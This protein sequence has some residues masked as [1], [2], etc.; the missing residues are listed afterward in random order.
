[1]RYLC[2]APKRRTWFQIETQTEADAESA[3]MRHSVEKYFERAIA[4]ARQ[5]YEPRPGLAFFE[6]D[7]GMKDHV[8]RT[9]PVFATL[10]DEEGTGLATAM[11]PPKGES[12]VNHRIIIVGADNADP[13]RDHAEAIEALGRYLGYRLD[14]AS[15]FPYA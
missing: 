1:M 14:R 2:D 11:L 15:C 13:Y 8:E 10:R 3:L 9:A 12:P 5:S 4:V 6:R 7:I